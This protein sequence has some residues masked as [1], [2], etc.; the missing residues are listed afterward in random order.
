MQ[1]EWKP[2]VREVYPF[3][4]RRMAHIWGKW[5][6]RTRTPRK[7]HIHVN[8]YARYYGKRALR[9]AGELTCRRG[10]PTGWCPAPCCAVQRDIPD[11]G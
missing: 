9:P 2:F 8:K 1:L 3:L 7:C 4:E 11:P 10:E 6:H 5:Q